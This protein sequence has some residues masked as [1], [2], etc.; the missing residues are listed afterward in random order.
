MQLISLESL[1][2][3]LYSDVPFV[4]IMHLWDAQHSGLCGWGGWM[5]ELSNKQM[6]W[7]IVHYSLNS[8]EPQ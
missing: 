7:V 5:I 8:Q 4:R 2:I 3:S 6:T 1:L